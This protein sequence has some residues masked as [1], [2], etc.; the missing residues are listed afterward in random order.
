MALSG[1]FSNAYRGYTYQISWS[2]S[3]N[4]SGNYST[5]T[6]THKL[7]C[8]SSYSLYISGRSNTCV[9]NGVSKGFTSSAI[10]TGGGTTITLGT[11]THTI[12]HNAN[13]TASFSLTGTFSMQATIVSTYVDKIVVTGSATLNTIPRSSTITS[14]SNV[15]LGNKCSVTFTPA[16]TSFQ[17]NIRFS[18]GSWTVNT[19]KF[20]P[21]TTSSYTYNA[22]AIPNTIDV[23]SQIPSSTT[24]TMTATLTTYNSSGIQIGSTSS[25]A[26]IVT[27][28]DSI[29]PTIGTI[30]LT[31]QT[32]NYLIQNKN[33]VKISISG[34]S[35]GVGSSI[36]SYTFSGPG[37]STTTTNTSVNT[38]TIASSGT[39]T[40]NVTVTDNRGRTAS[41]TA[42]IQ[43]YAYTAPSFKSFSAYRVESS[44]SSVA[45]SD[46]EYIR[47]AYSLNYSSVNDTNQITVQLQYK[48]GTGNWN[49]KA[50]DITNEK[51]TSGSTIIG[52]FNT[53][54][55]Y[56]VRA[57]VTDSYSGSTPINSTEI[58][59]FSAERILNIRPKGK[60]MA[61]GKMAD[62][63][64]V[65]DSKW[66]IRSDAPE[67]TM[68][69]LTYK[70]TNTISSTSND[71]TAKWGEEGNLATV[72]Y[73]ATGQ[74]T[75]QPSQYGFVLNLTN[76]PNSSEVHQL[77]A[78]QSSGNV[79]HRG[80]NSSGW[81]GTW[82]AFLDS[83][84]YTN[85]VSTKPTTLYSGSGTI[86][87]IT[88]SESAANFTYLEIF[89]A[90]NSSKQPNSVRIYSPNG[91][92][93]SLSCIEP[94]TTNN[95]ARVYI[96]TSGWTI[97]GS[98]MTVGR[99]DLSG[100]NRGAF[101]QLYANAGGSNI[102]VNISTNNYIKIFRVLGYK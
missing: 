26:F 101:A 55:T 5:I 29:K 87:T 102:D 16:S 71:T 41:T 44:S 92:Y 46:G 7:I 74:I 78:T 22:Y 21:G 14:A 43:C 42:D 15:T 85:W 54:Q 3:Q 11:T 66:P 50:S 62:K 81:N 89:Y 47:Y 13:G 40:Y 63:D 23:L 75:D 58:T 95:E 10:S 88:L 98:S 49:T 96:R 60:G 76:G 97:S 65:L 83:S 91:K 99:S 32:Y 9:V 64:D 33:T 45:N 4:I 2:A 28:P 6:C 56:V 79:L 67:E 30:T 94:S 90:D 52:T 86:G 38:S 84:N 68:K 34:C 59:I 77:W 80:G 20:T 82:R 19:G 57:I 72:F 73:T 1:T 31:P 24:A 48:T 17:Y 27:V 8:A 18:L 37:I 100:A 51:Q 12:N 36:R 69:N 70:G 93:V 39:A 53:T 61:L 35:A 25:K